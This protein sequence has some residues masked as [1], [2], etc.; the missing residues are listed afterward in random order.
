MNNFQYHNNYFNTNLILWQF[1]MISALSPHR[2]RSELRYLEDEDFFLQILDVS[3]N[4]YSF[5]QHNNIILWRKMAYNC[6]DL[7]ILKIIKF[8]TNN[9]QNTITE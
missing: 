8:V 3:F 9:K 2:Y 6:H 4:K 1:Y 5:C 7:N